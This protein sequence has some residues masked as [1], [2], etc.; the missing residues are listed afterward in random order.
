MNHSI[1]RGT[2]FVF[3]LS[4]ATP[5]YS[6]SIDK[7]AYYDQLF[8]LCKAWGHA[9]YYHSE[10]AKGTINWDDEL[11][12]TIQKI[13]QSPIEDTF[14][15]ALLSILNKAGQLKQPALEKVIPPDSLNN[16]TD[17]SW[18]DAPVFSDTVHNLLNEIWDKFSSQSNIYVG[19]SEG[20]S[21][22]LFDADDQYHTEATFPSEEKRLLALF[23]Y[24]NII[25]YFFPY[26]NLMD[27]DWDSTLKEFI[28][29]IVEVSNELDFHLAFKELTV[30]INDSHGFYSSPTYWE[31]NGASFTPFLVRFIENETVI[32]KVVESVDAVKVGDIIKAID[33]QNIYTLRDSLRKY[34]HGSNNEIIDR[35][36]NDFIMWGNSGP[37][38]LTIENEA[39]EQTITLNRNRSY[40]DEL[41]TVTGPIFR[42]AQNNCNYGIIDMGRLERE[43]VGEVFS[44][45]QDADAIIFDIRN[46]P[47]GT[48]WTIVNY[49]YR[50]PTTIA[51]FTVPDHA[52]PGRLYW[53]DATL[54]FGTAT[55][56]EGKIIILFD[57]RTQSQAEYTC[58]GLEQYP[59]VVKIGS[60]T[61]GA[62]GNVSRIYLPG[63]IITAAS[64]LGVFYPDNQPT[65]RIGILPDIEVR[66][67]IEGI[68]NGTDEVMEYAIK[69]VLQC[70]ESELDIT[71]ANLFPNPA[72]TELNYEVPN[73][74]PNEVISIE[75][76]DK[77]GRKVGEH[78]SQ[79]PADFVDINNLTIGTYIIRINT[80]QE[81]FTQKFIKY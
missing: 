37:F 56:Y 68:R 75:I 6:Q 70:E 50:I 47:R 19:R 77:L 73:T 2:L 7:N 23:R 12:V 58:M 39:G 1:I 26:K 30:H 40:T 29:K 9:K 78:Q 45:F 3:V 51:K 31:W 67:T 59:D 76:F 10:I 52:F 38:E 41:F 74:Q 4:I 16:N 21:N 36:L 8:Y 63:N 64:F 71:I 24:W 33:G 53:L 80:L 18:I 54:G 49:I 25:N 42:L 72:R 13:R 22:P 44:T 14:N 5:T 17:L 57:E 43:Q 46:Y 20:A 55:P 15:V 27:Q 81:T 69:E 65:Q 11:L 79:S 60:T 62:D 34:A 66:P 48:L 32:T 35:T 28:P 61:S